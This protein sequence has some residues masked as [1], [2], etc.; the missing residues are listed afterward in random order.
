MPRPRADDGS[1]RGGGGPRAGGYA[2][3]WATGNYSAHVGRGGGGG[4]GGGEGSG[5]EGEGSE[6]EGSQEPALS[7]RLAMWDLGQ[8]DKGRCTGAAGGSRRSARG[9]A[10]RS[11]GQPARSLLPS[12]LLPSRAPRPA[13]G[14][15]RR[16]GPPHPPPPA[17]DHLPL[18]TAAFTPLARGAGTRLVRQGL[19]K[20]LRLGV[21]WPGVVLSPAGT[22]VVSAEDGE[23]IAAKGLAVVDCSWNKLDEVPFGVLCSPARA[24][25]AFRLPPPV[26]AASFGVSP[27]RADAADE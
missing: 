23:L 16:Q 19:V 14:P 11:R 2:A 18:L 9:A 3:D 7:I 21:P 24:R 20:E 25:A 13:I 8:C 5:S 12:L 6:G 15:G 10:C 22:R 1:R 26:P 4:G 27:T 17:A